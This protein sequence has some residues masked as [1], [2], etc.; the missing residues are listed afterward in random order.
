MTKINVIKTANVGET[1]EQE[2]TPRML[3]GVQTCII[4]TEFHNVAP[5]KVESRSASTPRYT[6]PE[7]SSKG[8]TIIP[9][10]HQL[11]HVQRG[12]FCSNQKLETM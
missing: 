9:W 4:T 7:Q 2:N 10:E 5:Q 8:H 1:M 11:K 3:V 6:T 12:F